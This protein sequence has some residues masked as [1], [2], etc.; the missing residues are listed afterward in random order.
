MAK[1]M[2]GRWHMFVRK[3]LAALFGVMLVFCSVPTSAIAE[4][5][6]A[7]QAKSLAVE[8]RINAQGEDEWRS[9][10][11][12]EDA[13]EAESVA[14]EEERPEAS[15]ESGDQSADSQEAGDTE[16][17]DDAT[18]PDTSQAVTKLELKLSEGED[19]ID[20]STRAKGTDWS[21][22]WVSRALDDDTPFAGLK[23]RLP[24]ALKET[25]S[26]WYRV[27]AGGAW[28]DWKSNGDPADSDNDDVVDDVQVLLLTAQES[29][30]FESSG[31]QSSDVT[32]SDDDKTPV[33]LDEL[34]QLDEDAQGQKDD[35][36]SATATE[37][38]AT[39][40]AAESTPVTAKAEAAIP[41]LTYRV[42]AQTYGWMNPVNSGAVAGTTGQSKRLEAITISLPNGVNGG[43]SY[44][45][46]AQTYGWLNEASNGAQAGTTGQSKRLEAIKIWL[47]GDVAKNY[48]VWYRVHA[49]TYG[50]MG[51]AKDGAQ[52]GTTGMSKRL[53]AIQIQLVA[54]G[55]PAPGTGTVAGIN[56]TNASVSY[57]AY[58][59]GFGWMG[60]MRNGEQAGTTGIAMRMEGFVASLSGVS[61]SE[62]H[63]STHMQ[64]YGWGSEVTGGEVAG[65]PGRGKRMEAIKMY[66]TGT[67]AQNYDIYYRCHIQ[68]YGWL[69][70]AKNGAEAGSTGWCKR[71]EAVQVMLVPKGGTAPKN[72]AGY[73]LACITLPSLR[74]RSHV[75]TYGWQDWSVNGEQSG[76]TGQAKRMEA[77]IAKTNISGMSGEIQIRPHVQTYGWRDWVGE[78]Q[79]AGTTGQ[80]KRMEAVQ[81][82]LTGDLQKY[83]D[84][85]YCVHA[86][87]YGWMGWACNGASA[88]TE[89]MAKRLEAVQ[90]KLLPKGSAAPG[91]TN[92]PFVKEL[93]AKTG[94]QNPAGYYQVSSRNVPVPNGATY[95]FNYITPSRISADAS[96]AD[97][98][99]AFVQR[100][101]EY[102][103]TPY[104][105]NYACAPGVGVDCIGLVYQC[106]YATGMNLGTGTG[107][108]DF[109]PWAHWVTGSSGWHS[110]DANNFWNYGKA[111]HV[112]LASRQVGDCI[113]YSGHIA[114]YVGNDQVI[115]AY[116]GVG[117]VQRNMY[118]SYT[119]R[120]CIRLFQ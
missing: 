67:A 9:F 41:T 45:V 84:V 52:A 11:T 106:A 113:S 82:R 72:S 102:L 89:G 92:R 83:Y 7:E 98:V 103:G 22:D 87:T 38:K 116:P 32:A 108:E 64:T 3:L 20:V 75:Q 6:A 44:Q 14:Q 16:Q 90:I 66:L 8:F 78:G 79:V 76:T 68:T 39:G 105:W 18:S 70:W 46:H 96:R 110:H 19:V 40:A 12:A 2:K 91:S 94:Y 37:E 57:Q 111:L 77:L 54:K 117:V 118:T 60:W 29:E 85:W 31:F 59:Q 28:H 93:P 69:G 30:V 65:L 55:G 56:G 47:T 107:D 48:D 13:I 101:R 24:D 35:D 51:W 50:W 43:I 104:V 112:S 5:T 34:E 73:P 10:A 80:A 17:T 114:I 81:I 15:D 95:P 100:A 99:N 21:Q 42:H 25:H 53:E 119:P 71:I 26:V 33:Q 4:V 49:Q 120:G 1:I 27:H 74:Y 97:C 58:S 115:E 23:I 61:N 109:N 88:G 36:A 62:L 86:Q 63:Y